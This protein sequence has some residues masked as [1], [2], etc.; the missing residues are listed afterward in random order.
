MFRQWKIALTGSGVVAILDILANVASD[1]ASAHPQTRNWGPVIGRAFLIYAVA[2]VAVAFL[3]AWIEQWTELKQTDDVRDTLNSRNR[4]LSSELQE[5]RNQLTISENDLAAERSRNAPHLTATVDQLGTGG[6][7][8]ALPG[9]LAILMIATIRN[10]PP[11]APS[12]AEFLP[13]R[14]TRDGEE[15]Y[16]APHYFENLTFS[17][18]QGQEYSFTA[19][20]FLFNKTLPDPIPPGGLRRGRLLYFIPAEHAKF[21]EPGSVL[22]LRFADINQVISEASAPIAAQSSADLVFIPGTRNTSARRIPPATNDEPSRPLRPGER[23]S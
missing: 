21:L 4:E 22:T 16:G 9:Q 11:R 3:F 12:I 10:V 20:D 23:S 13:L 6:I 2:A 8:D 14:L 1:M 18:T 15:I 19:E 5:K 7:S 17:G